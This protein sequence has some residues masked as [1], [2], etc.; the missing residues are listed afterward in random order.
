MVLTNV[1]RVNGGGMFAIDP[2][3]ADVAIQDAIDSLGADGGVIEIFPG[4]S[5]YQF[6]GAV[7]S[8]KPNVHIKGHGAVFAFN[9]VLSL[10]GFRVRG[11]NW[12][13]D[14]IRWEDTAAASLGTSTRRIVSIE[15]V[16]LG[17]TPTD[18]A[19]NTARFI[20]CYFKVT[21]ANQEIRDY[22]CIAVDGNSATN[23]LMRRGLVVNGCTFIAG[24]NSMPNVK[25]A[26]GTTPHGITFIKVNDS[27][28]TF[29]TNNEF[30]GDIGTSTLAND[31]G[32]ISDTGGSGGSSNQTCRSFGAHSAAALTM[33]WDSDN[34]AVATLTGNLYPGS[35]FT[36]ATDSTGTVYKITKLAIASGNQL[37][38]GF[39]PGLAESVADNDGIVL[40]QTNA[41]GHVASAIDLVDH[42][43]TLVSGNSF[44][45]LST[46]AAESGE[47][48]PLLRMAVGDGESGHS[49]VAGN[50]F[51]DIDAWHLVRAESASGY[52][53]W[54]FIEDNK[55]GRIIP[56][57]EA[58][59]SLDRARDFTVHRNGFHN[60]GGGPHGDVD[61]NGYPVDYTACRTG[62]IKDNTGAIMD[63][64]ED[65]IH[66][67]GDN[68]NVWVEANNI[69]EYD[70]P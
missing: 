13:F 28:S 41:Y 50:V 14:G 27:G 68:E 58:I 36:I 20:N 48:G 64:A 54:V 6:S 60:V 26:T 34:A 22:Q 15:D 9:G 42:N 39:W 49:R 17:G 30:R 67:G 11:Q 38:V 16:S 55:F 52:I 1:V 57:C 4:T 29:I 2:T 51:E 23:A 5:N 59:V 63:F 33:V 32:P 53:P 25:I 12:T 37:S 66:D 8:D 44:T 18:Q 70:Y 10:Y 43:Q 45:F 56:K 7:L 65:M 62:L 40:T 69:A 19:S 47:G 24:V 35:T 21:L 3:A 31:E 61:T 46:Q